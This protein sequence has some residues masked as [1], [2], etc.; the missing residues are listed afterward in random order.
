[1]AGK[2]APVCEPSCRFLEQYPPGS[3]WAACALF[4]RTLKTRRSANWYDAL[5]TEPCRSWDRMLRLEPNEL[6]QEALIAAAALQLR[7][8]TEALEE[9]RRVNQVGPPSR[10]YMG[11]GGGD[12]YD[13]FGS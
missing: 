1:M 13:G 12:G 10:R 9:M 4:G 6:T 11:N 5:K 3:C 8:H 2:D 7:M